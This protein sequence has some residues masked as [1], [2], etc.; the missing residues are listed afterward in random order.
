MQGTAT[1]KPPVADRRMLLMAI[2]LGAVAAG[3]IVAFLATRSDSGDGT[4]VVPSTLVV[5]AAREIPDGKV[6][7]AADLAMRSIPNSAVVSGAYTERETVIGQTARFPMA[8]GEQVAPARLVAPVGRAPSFQIPAGMRGF[9]VPVD[10]T[11]TP[12]SLIVAG[13][14]VDVIVAA[15]LQ[16][17]DPE[18]APTPQAAPTPGTEGDKKGP[19]DFAG[20]VTLIQNVQVLA[21]ER[22]Y[23]DSGEYTDETRGELGDDKDVRYVTLIVTPEQAQLLWLAVD[24]GKLTLALRGWGDKETIDLPPSAEP[25]RLR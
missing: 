23:V 9:T 2:L 6:I 20:A 21:I 25:L 17:I 8:R 11:L 10:V 3:L 22:R 4:A 18:L 16:L 13:D 14:F 5:V 19:E 15:S 7:E 12:A 24:Q 1:A